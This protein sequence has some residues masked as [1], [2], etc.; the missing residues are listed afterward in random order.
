[1][2]GFH[3]PQA[4]G[5]DKSYIDAN[6][7]VGLEMTTELANWRGWRG[8]AGLSKGL[9]HLGGEGSR[10]FMPAVDEVTSEKSKL[11]GPVENACNAAADVNTH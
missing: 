1:M 8:W 5:R 11:K 4:N 7:A 2:Q 3:A 9:I 10:G 6:C